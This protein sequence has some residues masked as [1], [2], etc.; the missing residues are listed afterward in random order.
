RLSGTLS[1][2]PTELHEILQESYYQRA[3]SCD[4]EERYCLW[5]FLEFRRDNYQHGT[6]WDIEEVTTN[7]CETV[8][9]R[10]GLLP[11][12]DSEE[13]YYQRGIQKRVT[14]N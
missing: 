5:D 3:I 6:S 9:F 14:T 12:W 13:D 4:S 7:Q 2:P 11:T 8:G 10:R 1:K